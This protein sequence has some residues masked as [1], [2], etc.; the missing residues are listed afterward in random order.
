MLH[1]AAIAAAASTRYGTEKSAAMH[2]IRAPPSL[3]LCVC[4]LGLK[5]IQNLVLNG[6]EEEVQ[7]S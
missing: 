6:E 2:K 1:A 5:R 4:A 3:F 7:P